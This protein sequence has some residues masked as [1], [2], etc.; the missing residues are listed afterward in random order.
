[1]NSFTY[2]F[3]PYIKILEQKENEKK[4]TLAQTLTQLNQIQNQLRIENEKYDEAFKLP[5]L[6]LTPEQMMSRHTFGITQRKK[7]QDLQYIMTQQTQ[8]VDKARQ[9]LLYVHQE[10]EKFRRLRQEKETEFIKDE[11]K[12]EQQA[13]D[14]ISQRI[15]A[16]SF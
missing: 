7:C 11:N 10:I 2:R 12:R 3:D 14:E 15:N 8:V 1:M 5:Q 4:L 13:L 9:D 6:P 16:Q